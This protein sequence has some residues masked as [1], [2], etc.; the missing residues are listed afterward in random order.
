VTRSIQYLTFA[1]ALLL[2]TSCAVKESPPGGPED[3]T[4][5]TVIRVEPEP[6]STMIPVD[7]RF[8][9]AFSKPMDRKKTE[10]AVFLSPVF[11]DYPIMKWSGKKLTVI[12]PEE[13]EPNRTYVLTV[14]AGGVGYH[15]NKIGKSCSFA[16]ST[17]AEIDSG[18]LAGAVFSSEGGPRN[19][20]IWV[21]GI[22]DTTNVEFVTRIPEYATQVDSLG[23]FSISNIGPGRY[24]VIATDDRNDDL[25]WD[26]VSES[27]GLPPFM[28]SLDRGE[29]VTGIV[30]RPERRDTVQAYISRV[31]AV[32]DRLLT[33]EFSQPVLDSLMLD[34]ESYVIRSLDDTTFLEILD[35]YVDEQK[36]LVLETESQIPG[37]RYRLIPVDLFSAWG[38][39]FDTAGAVFE[40]SPLSDTLG[41]ALISSF[42]SDGS[43]NTYQDSTVELTFSERIKVLDFAEAVTVVADSVD[44]L[45]FTP[46]WIFPNLVRLRIAGRIPRQR[47]I[48]VTLDPASVLDVADN[49]MPDS[50]VALWFRLPP[51]DTVGYVT[52][53][54]A[55]PGAAPVIGILKP[56][57][58][59]GNIYE[60]AADESGAIFFDAVLPGSY[61]FEYFEDLDGDG[62]WSPGVIEPFRPAER[63]SFLADSVSVRSRWTT[64]IGEIELPLPIGEKD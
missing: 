43:R 51:A 6:G 56:L 23:G 25:F 13:L 12:P 22:D 37:L 20:D 33:V 50:V 30:L 24:I 26:P 61:Q 27:I 38:V 34:L 62:K 54:V 4:P 59:S 45:Q 42:P 52:A 18:M 39:P 2:L 19:Y 15:Q 58:R 32:N 35:G 57:S 60:F 8:T 40:G 16:F 63:F 53:S 17:G 9:I 46:A 48:D 10:S 28:V 49:P 64:D 21:Y 14:G 11:W 41:P 1:L 29:A 47:G 3:T 5:P 44:T 31:K 36:R 55:R 7:T